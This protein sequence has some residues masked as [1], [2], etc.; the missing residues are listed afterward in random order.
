MSTSTGHRL[1]THI[2]VLQRKKTSRLD[3]HFSLDPLPENGATARRC[4]VVQRSRNHGSARQG[5]CN[6]GSSIIAYCIIQDVDI[7]LVSTLQTI[8]GFFFL[9]WLCK[10]RYRVAYWVRFATLLSPISACV[11]VCLDSIDIRTPI[12]FLPF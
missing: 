2:R 9:S 3:S 4:N 10:R 8:S 12:L 1:S 6:M 7:D 11:T 5:I